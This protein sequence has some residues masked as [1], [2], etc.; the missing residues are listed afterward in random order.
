MVY[1][2]TGARK[3]SRAVTAEHEFMSR[4]SRRAGKNRLA[5]LAGLV[6]VA[7]ISYLFF[8]GHDVE[9]IAEERT[10]ASVVDIVHA[11]SRPN[12]NPSGGVAILVVE[13]PDGGRARVFAP[14]ANASIG[15]A[16]PVTVKRY[17]D[18][19]RE[20]TAAGGAR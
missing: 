4:L 17:S 6:A 3:F 18:G 7:G 15:A 19:S 1:N 11:A 16:I 5:I 8:G 13:L 9:L 20:I 12:D 2:R 14:R 10:D